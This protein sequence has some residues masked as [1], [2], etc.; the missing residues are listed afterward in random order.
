[1]DDGK[2]WVTDVTRVTFMGGMIHWPHFSDEEIEA[3]N[4][5]LQR[6]GKTLGFTTESMEEREETSGLLDTEGNPL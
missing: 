4:L 6:L 5:S 3:Y 1:M 2:Q